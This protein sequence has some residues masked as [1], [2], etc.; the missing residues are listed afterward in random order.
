[1]AGHNKWSKIKYKK[2]ATDGKKCSD[3]GKVLKE[4]EAAVRV[5]GG[6]GDPAHNFKLRTVIDKAKKLNIAKDKL[7]GAIKRGVEVYLNK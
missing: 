7:E 2:A 1:M 6:S 3:T 4:I 5:G